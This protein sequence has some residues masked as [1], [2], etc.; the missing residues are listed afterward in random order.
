MRTSL[1]PVFPNPFNPSTSIRYR[2]G[3]S[4]RVTLAI[5]DVNGRLVRHLFDDDVTGSNE[6]HVLMWDG[7]DNRGQPVASGV[8][9]VRMHTPSLAEARKMVLLK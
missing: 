7:S 3:S 8:Y 6:E 9:F 2:V 5:Y 1:E 4:S